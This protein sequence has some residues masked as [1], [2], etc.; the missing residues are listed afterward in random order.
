MDFIF[1]SATAYFERCEIHS[2]NRNLPVNGYVTAASTA[3]GQTYGYVFESCRFTGNCPP[4]TVYLGRPW[5]NFARTVILRSY[6]GAHIRPEG[7]HNWDK[8]EAE[9]TVFYAEYKNYGEG[10]VPETR[11]SWVRLLTKEEA[12]MYARE[13]VLEGTDGWNG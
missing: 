4:Q 11:P 10:F 12:E 5:R 9:A 13:R 2:K 8:K 3:E 6:L 7:W 1:G